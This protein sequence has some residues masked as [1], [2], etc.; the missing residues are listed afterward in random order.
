MKIKTKKQVS[1]LEQMLWE[2]LRGEFMQEIYKFDVSIRKA[3]AEE[4]MI[5]LTIVYAKFFSPA[6][7]R[8]DSLFFS[9]FYPEILRLERM[10]K[11]TKVNILDDVEFLGSIFGFDPNKIRD[12]KNLFPRFSIF[13]IN[14]WNES[15]RSEDSE[16]QLPEIGT[17]PY[18]TEI[19]NLPP[20]LSTE[21]ESFSGRE[22]TPVENKVLPASLKCVT[23]DS[24]IQ[25]FESLK[26][27]EGLCLFLASVNDLAIVDKITG[28]RVESFSDKTNGETVDWVLEG[29]G[30]GR[31]IIGNL[32][33]QFNL[34][35]AR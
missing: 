33:L 28:S 30:I 24:L 13:N 8:D 19:K 15:N 20:N 27:F 17:L 29:G 14:R 12:N 6:N 7:K 21:K 22:N 2:T 35:F 1:E 26:T 32:H 5:G 34:C 18:E 11:V 10:L 16:Y 9:V 3:P 31:T 25:A 23:D 4:L